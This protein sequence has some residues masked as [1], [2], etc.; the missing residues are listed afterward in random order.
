MKCE[1]VR[2]MGIFRKRKKIEKKYCAVNGGYLIDTC[3]T[4]IEI[5]FGKITEHMLLYYIRSKD[6]IST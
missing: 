6:S 1:V 2:L 3:Y 5:N 4:V